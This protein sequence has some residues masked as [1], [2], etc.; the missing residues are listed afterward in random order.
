MSSQSAFS[1]SGRP[2]RFAISY[3]PT[4]RAAPVTGRILLILTR[5]NSPE[6]RLQVGDWDNLVVPFFGLD[7]EQ[8]KPGSPAVIDGATPGFP[9]KSLA[10]MPAGDY[11]VQAILNVYTECH[12]SDGHGIWVHLDQWEG[13]QFN[14]SPGNLISDVQRVHLDPSSGFDVGVILNKTIPPVAVPLDTEWVKHVKVKSNLL[15]K[16]WG[17]PIYLGATVLLPKGYSTHPK[18]FYPAIYLQGHFSLDAPFGFDPDAKETHPTFDELKA[19]HRNRNTLEPHRPLDMVS[20]SLVA[21][22]TPY[23]FYRAWSSA[24]FPRM[25][26][27]TFQHPTPFYDDSYAVNSANNGP[28]GDAIIQ[29]LIP[30]VET[31]FRVIRQN[32][33]R[34]LTG[35]STGGWES[36]AL[37]VYHPD[38]FGGAW[39]FYPDP[40][41]FRRWG[42]VNI[43]EEKN[44]F[45]RPEEWIHPQR[46]FQRFADGQPRLT[47]RELTDLESVLG[48]Q[49]RSG[50]QFDAWDAVYGPVGDDGYPRPL[51]DP[52]T[53]EIDSALAYYMRDHGYDLRYYMQ[54][55]WPKLGPSLVGKIHI[56]CGDMDNFYL[57]LSVYLMEDFLANSTNPYYGG[58]FQYGRPMKGHGWQPTTNAALIR[59]MA[60]YIA[61]NAPASEDNGAW[62]YQ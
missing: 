35:G 45:E 29:E 57:N 21:Q 17:C 14:I 51:W 55:N 7:V 40:V 61:Q 4:A 48:G 58:S 54:T 56:V 9:V 26:A 22:E 18:S 2:L 47:A 53:G 43:Y 42:L 41:D 34:V 25:I 33:A 19:A 50:E 13:Q 30:E 31:R 8:W 28:Y 59:A 1:Q 6:P 3:P 38:F 15:S 39:A 49:M 52:V 16:F 23:E 44:F 27:V 32:Y 36:L 60:S 11:Y 20:A 24:D 12:R 37:Q 46:Y 62:H 5:E 10:S